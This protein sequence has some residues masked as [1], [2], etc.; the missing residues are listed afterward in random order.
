MK[1][2]DDTYIKLN[3][4]WWTILSDNIDISRF[5]DEFFTSALDDGYDLDQIEKFWKIG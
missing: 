1:T 5:K 2:T 4:L 3:E